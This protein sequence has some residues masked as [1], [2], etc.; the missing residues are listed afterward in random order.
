MSRTVEPLTI[1]RDAALAAM[2]IEA[3]PCTGTVRG[4]RPGS[5][6]FATSVFELLAGECTTSQHGCVI[7]I[8]I[9]YDEA[10]T[11][12]VTAEDVVDTSDACVAATGTVICAVVGWF[13]AGMT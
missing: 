8:T 12:Y 11:E 3:L 2:V 13:G 5:I 10:G 7:V 6:V 9:E 1:A 4:E